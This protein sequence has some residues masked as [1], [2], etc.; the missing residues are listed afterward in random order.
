MCQL[1]VISPIPHVAVCVLQS[2][3]CS[4][5]LPAEDKVVSIPCEH[6]EPV[7]PEKGDKVG[8]PQLMPTGGAWF[9]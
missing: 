6:L 2:G 1:V 7:Q 4:V 8:T 5:F 3:M 9:M